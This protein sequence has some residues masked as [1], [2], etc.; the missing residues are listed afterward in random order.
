[1]FKLGSEEESLAVLFMEQYKELI[2]R[3][4]SDSALVKRFVIKILKKIKEISVEKAVLVSAGFTETDIKLVK[5]H[6]L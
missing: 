1:M 2:E 3:R 4:C 5:F 6:Y